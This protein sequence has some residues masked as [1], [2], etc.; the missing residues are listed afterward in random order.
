MIEHRLIERMIARIKKEGKRIESGGAVDP[1]FIDVGT[2]FIHNYADLCHH[3]KEEKILFRDLKKRELTK[4]HKEKMDELI[5][6]H[7]WA[8]Q[9]TGKLVK[10]KEA[11]V[12][13]DKK[14]VDTIIRCMAELADF[15]PKHII[16][17][18]KHFFKPVMSYFTQNEQDA[19]LDEEYEFDRNYIHQMYTQIVEKWEKKGL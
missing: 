7:V 8:R 10:A 12:G 18:D 1:Q 16:K 4:E 6:E 2:D 3:G 13:G 9:T 15:Y 14:A 19:M 5:K 17:E 11:Y